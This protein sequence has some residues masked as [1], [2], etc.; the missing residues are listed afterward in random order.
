MN[1]EPI[2]LPKAWT[3]TPIGKIDGNNIARRQRTDE[4]TE[5]ATGAGECVR[6]EVPSTSGRLGE[7]AIEWYGTTYSI[8]KEPCIYQWY[9]GDTKS[10]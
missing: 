2:Y 3:K 6:T 9:N 5:V 10:D 7:R 8:E 4:H 1:E